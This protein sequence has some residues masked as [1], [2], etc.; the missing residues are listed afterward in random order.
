LK[1]SNPLV[2][3]NTAQVMRKNYKWNLNKASTKFS[4]VTKK[5]TVDDVKSLMNQNISVLLYELSTKYDSFS[6][7]CN[8]SCI[9][10]I[11]WINYSRTW[12]N[13]IFLSDRIQIDSDRSLSANKVS[14]KS[15]TAN[16][17]VKVSNYNRK[18]YAWIP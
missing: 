12:A 14:V 6:I 16:W 2:F 18:S 7:V 13:L 4:K 17:T 3:Q 11:D 8:D 9:F 5:Y 10:T 15:A 1:K